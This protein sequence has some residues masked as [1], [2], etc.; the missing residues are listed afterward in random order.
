MLEMMIDGIFHHN[1]SALITSLCKYCLWDIKTSWVATRHISLFSFSRSIFILN[2][3]YIFQVTKFTWILVNLIKIFRK[4][5]HSNHKTSFSL[6]MAGCPMLILTNWNFQV[7]ISLLSGLRLNNVAGIFELKLAWNCLQ[8]C[9]TKNS[10]WP[11]VLHYNN[12]F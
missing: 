2:S 7:V 11:H 6:N 3:S 10:L 12:I 8:S 9:N 4:Y 1:S 5:L